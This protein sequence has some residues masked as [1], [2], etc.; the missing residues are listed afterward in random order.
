MPPERCQVT[1]R[2]VRFHILALSQKDGAHRTSFSLVLDV[3]AVTPSGAPFQSVEGWREIFQVAWGD[4]LDLPAN[5]EL[6]APGL[7]PGDHV[8][9]EVVR[10]GPGFRAVD[11]SVNPETSV[12]LQGRVCEVRPDA[13][14]SV[15]SVAVRLDVHDVF[16]CAGRLSFD[17]RRVPPEF[18][19]QPWFVGPVDALLCEVRVGQPVVIRTRL[20]DGRWR[21]DRL[22]ER[23]VSRPAVPV[24]RRSSV[25]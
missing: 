15:P 16:G 11:L 9:L 12:F 5:P 23:R 10:D 20:V 13:A 6:A 18:S 22:S 1:G 14:S 7:R 2:L 19:A 8:S 4:R 21:L 24:R 17:A 3:T 25:A